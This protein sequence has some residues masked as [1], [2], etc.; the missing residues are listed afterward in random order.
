MTTTAR[1]NAAT[2]FSQFYD[3]GYTNPKIQKQNDE[4]KLS[5]K[6][7]RIVMETV[8]APFI[9]SN[10]WVNDLCAGQSQD[11]QKWLDVL[12]PHWCANDNRIRL[13]GSD[14]SHEG[15]KEGQRRMNQKRVGAWFKTFQC[16][17]MGSAIPGN[18]PLRNIIER[19]VGRNN[20]VSVQLAI[21]LAF[22]SD[23]TYR[24]MITNMMASNP[25][26]I[27]LTYPDPDVI[28]SRQT[29][30]TAAVTDLQLTDTF[31]GNSYRY[32]QKGTCVQEPFTEYLVEETIL[33][34]TLAE[35]GYEMIYD[36]S[37]Q[38]IMNTPDDCAVSLYKS[39][40]FKKL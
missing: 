16:D 26:V 34:S 20:I 6:A 21:S 40:V 14:I 18:H 19:Q 28:V 5:N 9:D 1:A 38:D 11:F 32:H 22:K 10:T 8:I 17:L 31:F 36:K 24:T 7:K 15:V 37:H 39:T 4:R 13:I 35:P 29:F 33:E 12:T 30:K 25:S 2:N 27:F 3:R 23:E